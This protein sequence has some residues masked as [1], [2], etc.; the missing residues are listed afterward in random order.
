MDGMKFQP[1]KPGFVD[2]RD[3]ILAADEALTGGDNQCEIWTAFARRGLGVD[4][5]QGTS[6]KKT[7][8]FQGFALPTGC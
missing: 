1:C 6:A 7:D 2:G 5:E 8:N 3:A 4:A